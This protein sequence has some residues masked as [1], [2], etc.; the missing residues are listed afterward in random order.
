MIGCLSFWVPGQPQP[1][2]RTRTRNGGAYTPKENEAWRASIV[3]RYREAAELD[4]V[5]MFPGSGEHTGHVSIAMTFYGS[6]ADVTNLVKEVEDA[7]NKVAYDDDRRINH[8]DAV[9]AAGREAE[10][11]GCHILLTFSDPAPSTRKPR[12]RVTK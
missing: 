7:L 5:T 4:R 3:A 6:K 11:P 10:T 12:K 1:Y 9:R 2:K 8:V